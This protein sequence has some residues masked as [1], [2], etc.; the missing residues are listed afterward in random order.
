MAVVVVGSTHE[1]ESEGAD[2]DSFELPAGQDELVRRVVAAN[3]NT[4]VVLNCGAPMAMPWL[5]DVPAALLAWYP[6]QEGGEAIADVL[7]GDADPGGRM[8]TTWARR[9]QDT[10]AYLNYP[11]EANTVHYGEGIYVGYRWYDA[12]G[13][14]PLI[15]FGH[16]SS[17]ADFAWGTPCITGD[18]TDVA[19][20]VPITNTSDRAGTDVVQLYIAPQ[21]PTVHRP[22]KELAGF[23]KLELAPGQTGTARLELNERSFARRDLATHNW[24]VDPGDYD[25]VI[26]ASATDTR[27]VVPHT[28]KEP[29]RS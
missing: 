24:K 5:N 18:G 23:A 10:P 2:R 29:D 11:G 17:C 28:L 6:G 7:L 3:P 25:L 20:E 19:V 16:G 12:R 15:P 13:I 27:A 21:A 4:V 14:D 1:W 9:E 26:A 8:P 22:R